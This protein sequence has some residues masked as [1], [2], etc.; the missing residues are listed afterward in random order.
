M[1]AQVLSASAPEWCRNMRKA[2]SQSCRARKQDQRAGASKARLHRESR[3]TGVQF[4]KWNGF[5]VRKFQV[6]DS[7]ANL[8]LCANNFQQHVQKSSL[9]TKTCLLK[10]SSIDRHRSRN[11]PS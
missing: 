5:D 10:E 3:Q 1:G 9:L 6:R 7:K 8:P 2:L 11:R 4:L